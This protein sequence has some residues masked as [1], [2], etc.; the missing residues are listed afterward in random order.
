MK[1]EIEP[2]AYDEEWLKIRAGFNEVIEDVDKK[3]RFALKWAKFCPFTR[4]YMIISGIAVIS[5]L[6]IPPLDEFVSRLK[7]TCPVIF[8]I[9]VVICVLGLAGGLVFLKEPDY[10]NGHTKNSYEREYML[11]HSTLEQLLE[12]KE[13]IIAMDLWKKIAPQFLKD[14]QW[15]SDIAEMISE[16]MDILYRFVVLT[17]ASELCAY[18]LINDAVQISYADENGYVY[19]TTLPATVKKNIKVD[20][21]SLSWD[22]R[23][24]LTIPFA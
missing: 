8:W 14:N 13:F 22:G 5:C 11:L 24:V 1:I 16:Y 4:I 18:E 9:L 21:P 10:P 3:Y 7:D 12:C 23:A 15:H 6:F 20:C 17:K 2:P 19:K